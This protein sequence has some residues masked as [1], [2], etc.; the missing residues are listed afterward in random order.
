V[1][2]VA[3]RAIIVAYLFLEVFER[4]VIGRGPLPRLVEADRER[5]V[6]YG[7][8]NDVENPPAMSMRKR[9]V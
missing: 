7:V 9:L 8:G 6:E 5:D 1:V 2:F 4:V 3:M